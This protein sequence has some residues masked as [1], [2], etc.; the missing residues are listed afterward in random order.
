MALIICPECKEK[1]SD[2]ADVCPKCGFKLKVS[3]LAWL[4]AVGIFFVSVAVGHITGN[5]YGGVGAFIG[6]MIVFII[7]S[8]KKSTLNKK[9]SDANPVAQEPE[10]E[11]EKEVVPVRPKKF[12]GSKCVYCGGEVEVGATYCGDCGKQQ[13]AKKK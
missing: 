1:V 5:P 2:S 7:Q 6:L 10:E 13:P 4:W 3:E 8:S 9:I 12:M 11:P